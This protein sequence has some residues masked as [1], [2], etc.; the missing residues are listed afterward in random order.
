[1]A[2]Y[3][4]LVQDIYNDLDKIYDRVGGLRDAAATNEKEIYNHTRGVLGDLIR[5]WRR[6]DNALPEDRATMPLSW[7]D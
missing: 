3:R 5:V 2:T 1:M 6:F 7:K 4:E